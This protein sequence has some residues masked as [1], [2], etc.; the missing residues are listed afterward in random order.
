MKTK[1]L[2]PDRNADD[3]N[4]EELSKYMN[5]ACAILSDKFKREQYDK[6]GYESVKYN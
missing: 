3:K 2:H 4:A 1:E 6:Y 5:P